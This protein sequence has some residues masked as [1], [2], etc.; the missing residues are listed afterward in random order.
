MK[1][2]VIDRNQILNSFMSLAK[3]EGHV[4]TFLANSSK[5][6]PEGDVCLAWDDDPIIEGKCKTLGIPLIVMQHGLWNFANYKTINKP[7]RAAR[8]LV[9]DEIDKQQ[10][11]ELGGRATIVGFPWWETASIKPAIELPEKYFLYI[12][13][14]GNK[15]TMSVLNEETEKQFLNQAQSL[16]KLHKLPLVVKAYK[17][18]LKGDFITI[19]NKQGRDPNRLG[20]ML[21]VIEHA[22]KLYIP[23]EQSAKK[24]AELLP[25]KDY[26]RKETPVA[27][28]IL[29]VICKK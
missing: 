7:L 1:I 28:K 25:Q 29:E 10:V 13:R 3:K 15:E 12:P 23:I 19:T 2:I 24:I 27:H 11:E 14:H 26:Y 18:Y 4:V 16:A 22:T 8:Y 20:N 6:L 9:Y 17:T 21:Y 5:G